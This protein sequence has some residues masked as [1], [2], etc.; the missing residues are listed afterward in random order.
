MKNAGFSPKKL[1]VVVLWEDYRHILMIFCHFL[2]GYE[3]GEAAL[4]SAEKGSVGQGKGV[5]RENLSIGKR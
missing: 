2:W 3:Q 4:L 1:D 5:G